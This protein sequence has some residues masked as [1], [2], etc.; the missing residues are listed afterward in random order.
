ML[1][2]DPYFCV[3]PDGIHLRPK[4]RIQDSKM[5]RIQWFRIRFT[6]FKIPF[7]QTSFV[8]HSAQISYIFYANFH[9]IN[10]LMCFISRSVCTSWDVDPDH[11]F[12]K[13]YGKTGPG[14]FIFVFGSLSVSKSYGYIHSQKLT[15]LDLLSVSIGQ[16]CWIHL[17]L[18]SGSV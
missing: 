10:S 16:I 12:T 3:D 6:S 13:N 1:P 9:N 5:I 17:I 18:P 2:C 7:Q 4:I 15:Y 11:D 8:I 14:S